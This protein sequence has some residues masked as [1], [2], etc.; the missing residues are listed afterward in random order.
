MPCAI[1]LAENKTDIIKT[2]GDS[3]ENSNSLFEIH[4]SL[5]TI[6]IGSSYILFQSAVYLEDDENINE[7]FQIEKIN[8]DSY[9]KGSLGGEAR[10]YLNKDDNKNTVS[11]NDNET[12]CYC[13]SIKKVNK[14]DIYYY[15]GICGK[16]A[17]ALFLY[18]ENKELIK[19]LTPSNFY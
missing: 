7:I 9:I 12:F 8:E 13:T 2:F 11:Y 19:S 1:A 4:K 3:K 17:P 18:S 10:G 16:N 15:K 6:P 5:I 14:G